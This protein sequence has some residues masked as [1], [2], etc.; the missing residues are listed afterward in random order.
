[1][2]IKFPIPKPWAFFPKS[3]K[4]NLSKD[5]SH[6]PP[7]ARQSRGTDHENALFD[8]LCTLFDNS[9]CLDTSFNSD[10]CTV[11]K[12]NYSVPLEHHVY[13][14]LSDTWVRQSSKPLPFID[15]NVHTVLERL[16]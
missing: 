4:K 3:G 11:S 12:R 5:R 1:M 14:I 10:V 13:D 6:R 7:R 16:Y 15:V 2:P 9:Y 8:S